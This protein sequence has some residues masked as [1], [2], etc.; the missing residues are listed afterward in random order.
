MRLEVTKKTDLVLRAICS[1]ASRG[2]RRTSAQVAEDIR[3][4]RQ[5]VPKLMEPLVREG[6]VGSTPGPTGGYELYAD[7]E[8][9]SLLQLIEA[10]EGPT[11]NDRCVLVGTPCPA[12]EPC[13][14]HDAWLPAREALLEKLDA[15]SIAKVSE[16]PAMCG[17]DPRVVIAAPKAG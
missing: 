14:L 10:V 9:I 17:P 12:P 15:T 2:G 8:E 13:A 5:I 3:S 6:W 7:L 16:S 1:L 4:S 11:E